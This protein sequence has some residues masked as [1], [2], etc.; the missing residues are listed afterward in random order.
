MERYLSFLEH[1]DVGPRQVAFDFRQTAPGSMF[2]PLPSELRVDGDLLSERL[3]NL[4]FPKTRGRQPEIVG[5]THR[6]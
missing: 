6:E 2:N 4:E 3:D 5:P 1:S